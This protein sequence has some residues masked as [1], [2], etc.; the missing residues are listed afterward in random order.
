[1]EPSLKFL[2]CFTLSKRDELL[3]ANQ[4]LVIKCEKFGQTFVRRSERESTHQKAC[5]AVF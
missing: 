2:A 1:M 5:F 4:S 3:K